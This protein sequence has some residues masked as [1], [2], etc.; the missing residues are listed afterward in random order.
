[1]LSA[2]PALRAVRRF[3]GPDAHVT[4]VGFE[5]ARWMLTCYE[6]LVDE[7]VPLE[8][9]PGLAPTAAVDP[10]ATLETLLGLQRRGFDLA[11]GLQGCEGEGNIV[12]ALLGA[13]DTVGSL[14]AGDAPPCPG[15]WLVDTGHGHEAA[16]LV[17]VAA[18]LGVDD[19]VQLEPPH[20]G[21]DSAAALLVSS[22]IDAGSYAV[23]HPG[24]SNAS[25]RW[26]VNG[27][28]SAA[29][30]LEKCGV[31]V[32]ITGSASEAGLVAAIQERVPSAVDL[33]GRTTIAELSAVLATARVVVCNDSGVAQLATATCTPS[34]VVGAGAE[35][36]IQDSDRQFP[37]AVGEASDTPEDVELVLAAIARALESTDELPADLTMVR[38]RARTTENLTV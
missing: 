24:A 13:R 22:G 12:L 32:A 9:C 27:F 31:P 36:V 37:V 23:V 8:T 15:T 11:V 14:A 21:A 10:A 4:L 3:G 1:M 38:H 33:T 29:A 17:A 2:V 5:S 18:Q 7:L 6:G 26:P 25:G 34:V 30:F 16:R 28:A 20:G 19:G 35:W